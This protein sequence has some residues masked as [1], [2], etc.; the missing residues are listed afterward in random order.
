M[1]GIASTDVRYAGKQYRCKRDQHQFCSGRLP[2][3]RPVHAS[4]S[5]DVKVEL[6]NAAIC[7]DATLAMC[8]CGA[9][10]RLQ[11]RVHL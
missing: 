6:A 3:S 1:A 11:D 10:G 4:A 5:S 7:T 2:S 9:A 8:T